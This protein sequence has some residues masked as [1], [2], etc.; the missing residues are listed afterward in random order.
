[1][2]PPRPGLPLIAIRL[3][4]RFV[5]LLAHGVF[6][7]PDCA[8]DLAFDLVS[9]AFRLELWIAHDLAGCLFHRA[10]CLVGCAMNSVL[11]HFWNSLFAGRATAI[12]RRSRR[13]VP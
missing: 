13:S 10:L 7:A 11:V 12:K 1:P 3:L 8:L 6:R 2:A 4:V 9:G 5:H